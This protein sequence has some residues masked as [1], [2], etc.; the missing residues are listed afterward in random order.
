MI[1]DW[2]GK[3]KTVFAAFYA[4]VAAGRKI[5]AGEHELVI[6]EEYRTPKLKREFMTG[7]VSGIKHHD[8]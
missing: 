6:P 3:L 2:V 8:S 7:V 4:G 5:A 1:K